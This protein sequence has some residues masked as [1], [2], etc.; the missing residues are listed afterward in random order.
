MTD[1]PKRSFLRPGKIILLL[2]L[3]LLAYA[4]ALVVWMPAGW[5]WSQAAPRVQLPQGVQVQQVSG[6]LWQGAA[7]LRIQQRPVR[8][9]WALSWPDLV[10][11]RQ[12]LDVTLET[13]SSRVAGDV[14]LG[15]PASVAVDATGR[16]H[17]PEFEAMIRQAGGAL[18]EGDVIIDRLRL[19]A[20]DSGLQSATGS[21]RWP[22]GEVSWP[23]G[24]TRQTTVFP[25]MQATLT[26]STRG[27]FLTV[28]EQGRPDPAA[29][30]TITYSGMMEVRVYKRMVDLAGQQWST[31]AAPGDVIFQVQQ[32]LVPGGRF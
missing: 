24:D 31:S 30:A 10:E 20:T 1:T 28:S 26:D 13:V 4:V 15:W 22:G 7:G 6:S 19:S 21:A 17:V 16:I 18:L 14:M 9:T 3:A 2:L 12:P 32:P 5:V 27:I 23:M 25:P 11:L 29:D 8:M